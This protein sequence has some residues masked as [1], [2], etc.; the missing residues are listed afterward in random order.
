[1]TACDLGAI[2]KP[3]EIQKKIARLVSDEFFYQGDLEKAELSAPVVPMMDR[4]L[5]HELPRLQ[6]GF[7]EGVCLPV[8][9]ALACLSPALKFMEE[10]VIS[11]RDKWAELAVDIHDEDGD[12]QSKVARNL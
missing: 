3:W 4:E 5:R 10:A 2:T 8:Y 12:Q 1:M 6:V 9:K 11:N 7:F